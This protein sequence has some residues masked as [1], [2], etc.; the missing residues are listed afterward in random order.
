MENYGAAN[1]D[2]LRRRI[3]GA[4]SNIKTIKMVY[5]AFGRGDL[6]ATLDAVTD[7]VDW[8]AEHHPH[9]PRGTASG[10]ARMV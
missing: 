4:D 1:Q 9:R 5:E 2:Q 6:Q 10:M 8:G 3:L 7:D